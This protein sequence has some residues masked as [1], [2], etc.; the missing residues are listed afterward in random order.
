MITRN[1]E[2]VVFVGASMVSMM[3]ALHMKKNLGDKRKMVIIDKAKEV[4]GLY[5]SFKY[6]NGVDF[7]YGVHMYT[8]TTNQVIDQLFIDILGEDAWEYCSGLRRDLSGTFYDEKL[9]QH[10]PF[11]DLRALPEA[12]KEEYIESLRASAGNDINPNV[13]KTAKDFLTAKFGP[14]LYEEVFKPIL[15]S[16]YR[17]D[18]AELDPMA[19]H[20]IPVGRVVLHDEEEVEKFMGDETLR[21][22]IAFP[23][24]FS[25]PPC[26]LRPGRLIY[27]KEYGMYKVV[28][29]LVFDLESYGVEFLVETGVDS[30]KVE[31]KKCTELVV[32]T[33]RD[34]KICFNNIAKLFWNGGYPVLGRYL[35]LETQTQKPEFIRAAF[36]NMLLDKA[37]NVGE[38]YYLYNFKPDSHIFRLVNY[39]NYCP[40][41][42]TDKGY[43]ICA[44]TWLHDYEGDVGEL[45]LKELR[46]TGI[47]TDHKVNFMKIEAVE[48]GF[49]NLTVDMV[50][51]IDSLRNEFRNAEYSNI[52]VIGML[53]EK[54]HF[55]L[56]EA[57]EYAFSLVGAK[58][59]NKV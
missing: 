56:T 9:Q 28:D 34:E 13:Y 15:V 29:K 54:G 55:Y 52:E 41:S 4:G 27:P 46:E 17:K 14:L 47:I 22:R 18:P 36:V 3:L 16:H 44:S 48:R 45:V 7:D 1:E 26:Y 11:V 33:D 8:E 50:S 30:M 35:G 5:R 38:L 25:L 42:V 51:A 10:T 37:P 53:A 49:P 6:D 57:L 58:E 40:A 39:F 24:Q 21:T 31:A 20:V 12:K 19:T 43:P 23:D 59:F 32:S 2:T